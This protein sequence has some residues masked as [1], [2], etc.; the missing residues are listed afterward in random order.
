[1]P[2]TPSGVSSAYADGETIHQKGGR[3]ARYTGLHS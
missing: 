2:K 1:M 3:Y